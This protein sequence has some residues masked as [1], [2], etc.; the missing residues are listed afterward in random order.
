[1]NY[2]PSSEHSFP[3]REVAKEHE[4]KEEA[5]TDRI[6]EAAQPVAAEPKDNVRRKTFCNAFLG[7]C[8]VGVQTASRLAKCRHCLQPIPKNGTR[9]AYAFSI[10]KFHSWVH[11]QCLPHLLLA[12]GG[13]I[14]QAIQFLTGWQES[15]GQSKQFA[16]VDISSIVASLIDL[17][18]EGV[19]MASSSACSSSGFK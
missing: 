14:P 9:I 19:V 18:S 7:V 17:Q 8:D 4:Q 13:D 16:D 1:M 12:E 15:K 5:E 11:P 10:T 3:K 2:V 6:V